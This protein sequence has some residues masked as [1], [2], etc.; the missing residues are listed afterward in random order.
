M[1][2]CRSM[3]V[4]D[5]SRGAAS[6]T[7]DDDRIDREADY[8]ATS[9]KRGEQTSCNHPRDRNPG[10]ERHHPTMTNPKHSGR[11]NPM[12]ATRA[13][14]TCFCLGP[15]SGS[16]QGPQPER[17]HSKAGYMAAPERFAETSDS[18]LAPRAPSIHGTLYGPAV[19][20]TNDAVV[21]PRTKMARANGH[22]ARESFNPSIEPAQCPLRCNG[23]LETPDCFQRLEGRQRRACQ[24]TGSRIPR[25]SLLL[26]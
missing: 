26:W 8:R 19:R 9:C 7:A 5:R 16:H 11:E 2:A 22:Q 24:K 10:R 3:R 1:N 25:R 23:L 15:I 20:C 14:S 12:S 21:V 6:G 17:L 4:P 13:T 18:S